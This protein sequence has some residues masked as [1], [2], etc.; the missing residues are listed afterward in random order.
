MISDVYF[1]APDRQME[2]FVG[3][4]AFL[5]SLVYGVM[6]E[7]NLVIPDIFFYISQHLRDAVIEE[8]LPFLELGIQHGYITPAFRSEVNGSFVS[9]LK[10][11]NDQNIQGLLPDADRIADS[12]E[13]AASKSANFKYSLWPKELL[14]VSYESRLNKIF[15]EREVRAPYGRFSE[16][17]SSL[18]PIAQ[19]VLEEAAANTRGGGIQRGQIYNSLA[20]QLK[21]PTTKINDI[22]DILKDISDRELADRIAHF[23]KWV[24]YIYQ[25]NQGQSFHSKTSLAALD[26]VDASFSDFMYEELPENS[27]KLKVLQAEFSA[28]SPGQLLT[29]P[30]DELF[31]V[32]NFG[33]GVEYFR[34]LHNWQQT[35]SENASKTLLAAIKDYLLEINDLYLR[36]GK[37]PFNP[38]S[39]MQVHLPIG[40]RSLG[41][42]LLD[43]ILKLREFVPVISEARGIITYTSE[44]VSGLYIFLPQKTQGLIER[45]GGV[46][47]SISFDATQRRLLLTQTEQEGV[48]A[49]GMFK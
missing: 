49:D 32:R 19:V 8:K 27:D 11:I 15:I 17:W 30:S 33:S 21:L 28:P 38:D 47:S 7:G 24:N 16:I 26:S 41:Y 4:D 2:A 44:T 45:L 37:N 18:K 36:K 35:G 31:R 20:K 9:N 43:R 40:E 39:N 1:G 3:R 5:R 13:A 12:L 14:S 23:L 10:E 25:Y 22:K 29:V 42:F 34:A 48:K 6:F 46:E